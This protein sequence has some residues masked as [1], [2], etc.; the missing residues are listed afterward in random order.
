MMAGNSSLKPLLLAAI[1]GSAWKKAVPRLSFR[2]FS[3]RGDGGGGGGNNRG[4]GLSSFRLRRP[5]SRAGAGP[6]RMGGP[7]R[8]QQQNDIPQH[9]PRQAFLRTHMIDLF[10]GD[11]GDDDDNKGIESDPWRD[12]EEEEDFKDMEETM[13]ELHE[14][15]REYEAKKKRW[16][17]NSIP[18]VRVPVIDAVGRSYGRGGRKRA[19]ARVWITPGFGQVT[20]N[21][22][23]FV[24]YFKRRSNR[25]IILDPMVVTRTC[26][27]FDVQCQVNGGGL[28][29]QAGAIRLGVA[30]ALQ[31]WNPLYRP[32]LKKMGYLTRDARKVERKKIGKVKARKSPQW[33]RR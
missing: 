15:Q 5:A 25:E 11:Y 23:D 3:S 14:D 4:Q 31:H 26:G 9:L 12:E 2:A 18:P 13:A 30:R 1:H 6:P 28:T 27:R 21:R 16:L 17:A 19:Q 20:V 8:S 33:N 32:P 24:D 29:G 7:N 10:P 22:I